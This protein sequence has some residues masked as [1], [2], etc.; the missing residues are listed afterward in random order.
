MHSAIV[1]QE[2]FI[3]QTLPD[4]F[5]QARPLLQRVMQETAAAVL[6]SAQ[7]KKRPDPPR[8]LISQAGP[9]QAFV[10]WNAPAKANGVSGY[11]IYR[12][13]E[14]NFI[15]ST[16]DATTRSATVQMPASSQTFVY[17]S[18][19]TD[20]GRESIKV[21]VLATSGAAGAASPVQPPGYSLE[22]TGGLAL[23]KPNVKLL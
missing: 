13:N 1:V 15:G 10:T 16:N 14:S 4:D 5:I 11:R 2:Y 3:Y 12:D 6:P 20:S 7:T 22:P 18:S 21:Q 23:R 8:S 17:V 19:V 9:S